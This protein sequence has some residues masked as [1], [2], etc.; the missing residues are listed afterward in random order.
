LVENLY[1]NGLTD[2]QNVLDTQRTLFTQQDKLAASQGQVMQALVRV[3]KGFGCGWQNGANALQLETAKK[4]KQKSGA[5][6]S[7]AKKK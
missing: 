1:K 4:S 6:N 3:Y 5:K 2:F 7:S